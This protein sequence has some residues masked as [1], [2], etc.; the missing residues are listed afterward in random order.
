MDHFKR[1]DNDEKELYMHFL[2]WITGTFRNLSERE[3]ASVHPIINV[4]VPWQSITFSYFV[5][6]L[7]LSKILYEI[8]N[9]VT[10]AHLFQMMHV[11]AKLS[12]WDINNSAH[13]EKWQ[14]AVLK[15]VQ[16]KVWTDKPPPPVIADSKPITAD[17]SIHLSHLPSLCLPIYPSFCPRASGVLQSRTGV[18]F[19]FTSWDYTFRLEWKRGTPD[20][21]FWKVVKWL[22]WERRERERARVDGRRDE[23]RERGGS[24]SRL[25]GKLDDG[26]LMEGNQ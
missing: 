6:Q 9:Y 22:I 14:H 17:D 5:L 10:L 18:Q 21:V 25:N 12:L 1:N 20:R 3:Q 8:I 23:E 24:N 13:L 7:A 15:F 16:S 19:S 26:S 2:W 11:T 4:S